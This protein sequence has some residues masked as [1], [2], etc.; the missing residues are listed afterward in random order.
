MTEASEQKTTDLVQLV[1]RSDPV[2]RIGRLSSINGTVLRASGLAVS[3]GQACILKDP[4][5]DKTW[6]A[7]VI[8]YANQ[9]AILSPLDPLVGLPINASV[10]V[11]NQGPM[12]ACG[13]GLV[14]RVLGANGH[15]IDHKGEI[16]S[17]TSYRPIY[18]PSPN[19]IERPPITSPISTGVRIIDTLLTVG[20]GQRVGIFAAAGVGKSTLL[21][22]L[23]RASNADRVV[24]GLVGERGRELNEILTETLG[25]DG[26]K[27]AV[28]VIATSDQPAMERVRA[29]HTATAIAEYFRD[30]AADDR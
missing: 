15:P 1:R 5:S 13:P 3:I 17:D 18:A 28:T 20:H 12:I 11:I 22:M 16:G 25:E 30:L 19:P 24:F 29:A 21:G 8:G 14:G 6:R 23:A 9:E 27:R 4:V 2:D 10:H 26:L 7:E